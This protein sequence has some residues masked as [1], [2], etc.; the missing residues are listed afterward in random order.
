MI[1]TFEKEYLRELYEKGVSSDKK[2]RF[3]PEV[4]RAYAKCIYR[5]EEADTLEALYRYR[6]LC[7]E[8][9]QGNKSGLFSIRVNL[10][11]RIEF[12][13]KQVVSEEKLVETKITICNIVELSNHYQ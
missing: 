4:V 12:E 10:R 9:L 2:H 1:I 8:A 13:I 7:L 5:L 6:S 3:Q 11:Y